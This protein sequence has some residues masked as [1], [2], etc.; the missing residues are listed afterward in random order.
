MLNVQH[1]VSI[2]VIVSRANFLHDTIESIIHQTS[3]RWELIL[4]VNG[5]VAKEKYY[6]AN[7][8][9]N[10]ASKKIRVYYHDKVGVGIARKK[11][12]TLAR[13][14]YILPVDDDD[15][16]VPG[17][18]EKV[19]RCF[20]KFHSASIVRGGKM[21]VSCDAVYDH[22]SVAK[23]S[24]I[25][26]IPLPRRNILGMTAD[27]GNVNQLYCINKKLLNTVGELKTYS[28]FYHVGEEIDLFLKLEEKGEIVWIDKILY[29]KRKHDNNVLKR[30]SSSELIELLRRYAQI[31]IK[32]RKLKIKI[33]S[34]RFPKRV[35]LDGIKRPKLE[36]VYERC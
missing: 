5:L 12:F 25:T 6:V 17:A 31:A 24:K 4:L 34:T 21:S 26:C 27:I 36:F 35:D 19:L 15:M 18:V 11:L 3:N 10:Y 7:L 22:E 1:G 9:N 14:P 29:L 20:K 23:K 28:D 16:I 33:V 32:R 8:L 30:F 13:Y 2:V